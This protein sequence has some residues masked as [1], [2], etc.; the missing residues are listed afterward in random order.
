MLATRS[1][2]QEKLNQFVDTVFGDLAAGYGGVMVS[3]GRRLG[4]YRVLAGAGPLSAGEVAA[5]AGCHE[6]Y[7]REWLNSQAAGGYVTY[8]P[9]SETYELPSEH[10]YVLADEDSPVY[11]APAW[12]VPASMWL[13]ESRTVE[14]FRTG[15]GMAWGE[16][17]DRLFRG[18]A[19]FFKNAY[20]GQLV[21]TWLPALE[22]VV[23]KLERGAVVADIGC[24]HGHSVV[25]MAQAFP[26]SRFIGYDSHEASIRAAQ[27]N[28]REGMVEE[29]VRF[30]TAD[31]RMLTDREFD[32]VCFFDCLHDMGDPVAAAARARAMLKPDGTALIVEPFANDQVI[33]NLNPVGRLYYS[34]S[35]TLC[36]AHALSEPGGTALG[37]QAGEARLTDVLARA[38]FSRTRCALATRFNLILEARP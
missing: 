14:V 34:A 1:L 15:R 18:V 33:D 27:A 31:A 21:S 38:G 5:R 29:R 24:G 36:C 11:M 12:E 8:H 28:A 2:D 19:A 32:L 20:E 6:R 22:G 4:L 9:S 7:V 16:H 3:L 30:V 17:D 13:D 23:S 25:I 10:A 37:A 26:A 35:T